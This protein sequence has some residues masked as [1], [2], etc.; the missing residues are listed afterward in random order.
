ML[1]AY[2]PNPRMRLFTTDMVVATCIL[3]LFALFG[4]HA[5][6]VLLTSWVLVLGYLGYQQRRYALLHQLLSTFFA[7]C[8][9]SFAKDYYGYQFDYVKIF[10]MNSLPLMA[11][12]LTLLGLGEVC[13]YLNM[14][15]KIYNFLIFVLAF[16]F[17]LIL[18]ETVAY[19][20]LEIRN[21]VTG[22]FAGLPYCNCIHA[23]TWMKVVYFSM[24]PSYYLS[25]LA[26]DHWIGKWLTKNSPVSR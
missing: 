8:W 14:S 10:G 21:T 23:P 25:T 2:I 12:S 22:S 11:W 13:N 1:A 24:G 18:F 5:D 6:W 3:L 4:N 7:V 20:V 16:W 9:V 26:A 17:F 19:H 15:K